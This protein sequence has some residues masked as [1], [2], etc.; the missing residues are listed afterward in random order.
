[1]KRTAT[2]V[3]F[4][5]DSVTFGN[6]DEKFNRAKNKNVKLNWGNSTLNLVNQN[7]IN[8]GSDK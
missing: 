2:H 4:Q 1:M 8:T 6:L 7:E 5:G 3:N